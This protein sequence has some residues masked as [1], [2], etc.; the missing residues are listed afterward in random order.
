[1]IM[2]S[3]F[4]VLLMTALTTTASAQVFDSSTEKTL[5]QTKYG[6]VAGYIERGVYTYKGIPYAK[7]ERFLPA[8]VPKA[9]QGVRS[10]R[11]WGPVCPQA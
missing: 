1:M 4:I 2:K 3:T 8:Q 11:H 10:S 9:W 5:A 7:A 6:Q